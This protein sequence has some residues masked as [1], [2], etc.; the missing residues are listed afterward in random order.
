MNKIIH[1]NCIEYLEYLKTPFKFDI[2]VTSPPYKTEDGYSHSLMT[3]ISRLLFERS[4][5]DSLIFVNFGHL[6]GEKARPFE[7]CNIFQ[8]FFKLEET[9]IWVKNHYRPIQ[10][11]RRVNN[12]FEYIFM[13]SCGRM[14]KLDRLSVGVPYQDKSNVG[15]YS[16]KD[17][18]CAG[19]VLYIP[20]ETITKG[21]QKL[22]N[23]RF[24]VALPEH[25][26][27]LSNKTKDSL[28][29]DPFS[30][31]GTTCVAAK[32]LG[33]QYLGIEKNIEHVN[34]SRERLG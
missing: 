13:F 21:D 10:G 11:K 20:Y 32:K 25:F 19:N 24:P 3:I 6:A 15:R 7:V 28:V 9:F 30:G 14:P 23:D 33:M 31:S 22:H 17:L 16:D 27:K 4:K 12:L 34:V 5:D 8:S 2:C 26:I 1:N 29:I 18:K